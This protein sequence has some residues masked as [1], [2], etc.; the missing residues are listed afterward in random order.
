[1]GPRLHDLGVRW[2]VLAK[3]G[4]WEQ[5]RAL[6]GDPALRVRLDDD[7]VRVYE[8]RG[9]DG[10]ATSPDG[11]AHRLS[12][13]I[14]PVLR[15]DAPRGS[16][17]DVAGAPG[18]LQGWGTPVRVT[19]DGRLRLEGHGRIV[20][21]WPAAALAA[22][23]GILVILAAA[24]LRADRRGSPDGLSGYDPVTSD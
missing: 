3:Q 16:V 23:D 9:W 20:W 22:F 21:F 13:P 10:P 4:R 11:R 1:V 17:L 18:W 7:D 15:T 14:P 6:D 5:Y 8:V 2:V 24:A 19:G 12:R